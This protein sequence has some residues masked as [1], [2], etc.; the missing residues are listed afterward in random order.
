MT[1]SHTFL[2]QAAG[3]PQQVRELLKK[4][5][6]DVRITPGNAAAHYKIPLPPDSPQAGKRVQNIPLPVGTLVNR[7]PVIF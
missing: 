6:E 4:F 7:L 5:I 3:G 1:T 2:V